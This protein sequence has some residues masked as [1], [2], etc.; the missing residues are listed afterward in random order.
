MSA[1]HLMVMII[2]QLSVLFREGFM[3]KKFLRNSTVAA[4]LLAAT[5]MSS[6]PAA[7]DSVGRGSEASVT[8]S[9]L[10]AVGSTFVVAGSAAFVVES[11]STVA[12][13]VAIVL[14]NVS[15]GVRETIV[16]SGNLARNT[17]WV[18][19]ETLHG[20]GTAA[21]TILSTGGTVIAFVPN[22]VGKRLCNNTAYGG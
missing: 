9:V 3:F 4:G 22:E 5:I 20:V 14:K 11:V 15:T 16:V 13:G 6:G 7:A 1:A 10:S 19:G 17:V 21:G 18:V 2:V 12:E 8:G